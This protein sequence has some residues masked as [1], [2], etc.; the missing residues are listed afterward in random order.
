MT[1]IQI[2]NEVWI[3]AG[4]LRGNYRLLGG[5]GVDSNDADELLRAEWVAKVSAFDLYVHELVSQRLVNIFSGSLPKAVAFSNVR[6]TAE[7][8]MRMADQ[9]SLEREKTF[10][11]DVRTQLSHLTFQMPDK[12]ADAIRLTSDAEL[13]NKVSAK[14]NPTFTL[15]KVVRESKVLR[16]DLRRIIDR[17]NKIAHEGDMQPFEPRTP[18]PINLAQV[19]LVS[20]FLLKLVEAID[21]VVLEHDAAQ[22][23]VLA[24]QLEAVSADESE[25]MLLGDTPEP[26]VAVDIPV[27]SGQVETICSVEVVVDPSPQVP[28]NDDFS[29]L[30]VGNMPSISI[31]DN[32]PPAQAID[33]PDSTSGNL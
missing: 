2:F 25:H 13:W 32:G 9:D 3:R 17:R 19:D 33:I 21:S 18:W 23:A 28:R 30:D 14:L 1:P 5:V 12:V 16:A 26:A 7:T 22:A 20:D 31:A 4:V 29:G 15:A 6:V 27:S 24:L 11:L 10:D 8:A